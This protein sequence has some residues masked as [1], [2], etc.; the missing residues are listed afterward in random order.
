MKRLILAL[1]ITLLASQA[2]GA[3]YRYVVPV[4]KPAPAKQAAVPYLAGTQMAALHTAQFNPD[5]FKTQPQ[6]VQA[7]PQQPINVPSNQPVVV[8]TAPAIDT[9]PGLLSWVL[10]S[11]LG[12]GTGGILANLFRKPK[13]AQVDPGH[14]IQSPEFQDTLERVLG[15][16]VNSD[17][18]RGAVRTGIGFIPGVGGF[19]STIEDV[20]N[21]AA[22]AALA[23]KFGDPGPQVPT[24]T[25]AGT[26]DLGLDSWKAQLLDQ[27]GSI[28]QQRIE[29][30]LA[31]R[32]SP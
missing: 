22:K 32:A 12:V 14:L 21:R 17:P 19:A 9:Q 7:Q 20:A 23:A 15:K 25:G 29:A 8:Q 4:P 27:V 30:A 13:V 3:D 11:I 16:L 31:K 26:G 10:T 5:P 18:L 24:S 1:S 6:V 28:V 2:I